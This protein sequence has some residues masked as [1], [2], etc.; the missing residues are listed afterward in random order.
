M[1]LFMHND[2]Y[3]GGVRDGI[4]MSPECLQD[5]SSFAACYEEEL[6]KAG[7]LEVIRDHDVTKPDAPLFLFYAFHLMHTPLQVHDS[8]LRKIDDLVAAVGGEKISSMDR[9]LYAAMALYMDEAIGEVV[10]AIKAKGMWDN[11][12]VVFS[13]TTVEP[14]TSL[15]LRITIHSKAVST[16]IGRAASA[17]T[18][19]SLEASFHRQSGARCTR[20]SCR[21]PI[22]TAH[23]VSWRAWML[24]TML[25]PRRTSG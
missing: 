20:A 8:Y 15:V 5:P 3:R 10:A 4:T 22:G 14:F 17:S 7:A 9:R 21:L 12:L 6:F 19:G 18:L 23:C 25:R 16:P 24:Q 2:T 1:D 11:T 13:Y